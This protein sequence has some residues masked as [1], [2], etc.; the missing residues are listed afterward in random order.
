MP[1][2]RRTPVAKKRKNFVV[3]QHKLDAARKALG[4]PTDTATVDAALDA[5]V[6]R[7]ELFAALDKLAEANVFGP[8]RC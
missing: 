8:A 4:L 7:A 2:P 5:V 3:D 1:K 6:F